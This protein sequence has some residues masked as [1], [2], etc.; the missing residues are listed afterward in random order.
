MLKTM[1]RPEFAHLHKGVDAQKVAEEIVSIGD[2]ATAQ[3]IVEYAT[4][5]KSELHKCFEWDD[6]KAA[7][8]YRLTQAR[9]LTSHLV[10]ENSRPSEDKPYLRFLVMADK[11]EGYKPIDVVFKR[12]DEYQRLLATAMSEL[13]NFKQKYAM[14]TELQDIF[15]LIA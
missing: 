11:S 15:D 1:W 14:L 9:T 13:R 8:Q 12:V 2:S 5:E 6:T 3:Q 10:V 4:N 7:Y